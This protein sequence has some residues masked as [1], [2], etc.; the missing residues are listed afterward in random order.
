MALIGTA[1]C[2]PSQRARTRPERVAFLP[3]R[4]DRDA[5]VRGVPEIFSARGGGTVAAG[6]SKAKLALTR[7]VD[8]STGE[9]RGFASVVP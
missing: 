4:R 8:R 1:V 7:A 3:T 5:G 2:S 6:A 9:D